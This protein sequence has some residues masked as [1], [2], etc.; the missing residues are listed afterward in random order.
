MGDCPGGALSDEVSAAGCCHVGVIIN[1]FEEHRA[2]I[3]GVASNP[4]ASDE[5]AVQAAEDQKKKTRLLA[6]GILAEMLDRTVQQDTIAH[7]A[8]IMLARRVTNYNLHSAS[9][10]R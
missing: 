1:M 3:M 2:E 6:I 10:L 4:P 9:W 7:S 8:A 5:A